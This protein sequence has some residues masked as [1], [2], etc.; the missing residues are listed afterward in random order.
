MK[1]AL[2][3]FALVFILMM[4]MQTSSAQSIPRYGLEGLEGWVDQNGVVLTWRQTNATEGSLYYIYRSKDSTLADFVKIDSTADTSYVDNPAPLV[5]Q[6]LHEFYLVRA[7]GQRGIDSGLVFS[8]NMIVVV[9]AGIPSV[10]SYLLGASSEPKDSGTTRMDYSP[11]HDSGEIFHL[12]KSS[13]SRLCIA[14]R[15]NDRYSVYGQTSRCPR[16]E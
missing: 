9:I 7:I 6:N 15:F 1:R 10:G 12:A 8:S 5:G 4:G 3:F 11:D 13:W 16:R 2:L 14:H